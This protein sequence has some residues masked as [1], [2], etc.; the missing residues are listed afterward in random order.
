MV[1]GPSPAGEG[2]NGEES[3][4]TLRLGMATHQKSMQ[5]ELLPED[6]GEAPNVRRSGEAMPAAQGNERSG[7]GRPLELMERVVER[8]NLKLALQRVRKNK[9]SPGIDG[10]SVDDLLPY[11][12]EN[13][14]R[15]RGELLGGSYRP[16]AVRRQEIPKS[17]GSCR[18]CSRSAIPRFQSTATVSGRGGGRMTQSVRRSG[19]SSRGGAGWWTWIWRS[20]STV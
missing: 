17:G 4:T 5:M 14:E 15:I 7:N 10:M 2:P 20:S 9:G 6:R 19:T 11:L 16:S 18:C 8:G 1:K 13:W 3:E 12:W